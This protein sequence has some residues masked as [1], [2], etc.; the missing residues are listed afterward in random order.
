MKNLIVEDDRQDTHHDILDN[1]GQ[2]KVADYLRQQL[3]N[4]DVFRIVSAYFTIYGF[5]ALSSELQTVKNVKFLFGDP[6]SV[7]NLDPSAKFEKT[8]HIE[9]G[10]SPKFSLRQKFLAKKCS[11]WV[12]SD[13]VKIR[14]IS[15][16]NFLHGKMYLTETS[17]FGATVVGSSNFTRSGLGYGERHNIEINSAT[18]NSSVR[19]GLQNWFDK[20]WENRDLTKDVKESVIRALERIGMDVPPELIYYKTLFELFKDELDSGAHG[21]HEL[22]ESHLYDTQ[23]WGKL[24]NFQKDGARTV[25]NRLK[26]LGGCILADSVGLG[27]TYTTLAVIKYFELR[28]ERV[29]V[30]CPRKLRENWGLYPIANANINNPFPKDRFN[31]TLLS[32]TDLSRYYGNVGGVDLANFMWDGF[33][34]IVIDE[35]H[36]F[37]NES[38]PVDID[39]KEFHHTR[40][41]RLLSEVLKKGVKSKVLMLSATPVNTTLYDLRNQIYLMTEHRDDVW[42]DTL[43]ISN[44]GGVLRKAQD[45]FHQWEKERENVPSLDKSSLT[46]KLGDDFFRL[47]GGMSIARSRR[48]IKK[49]YIDD[50]TRIGKFPER[51]APQNCYPETDIEQ[52]LSYDQLALDIDKLSLSLYRPS[53]YV[54]SESAKA[55]LE[56]ER[57]IHQFNQEDREKFLIGMI[58]T[59]FLKRLESSI[60]SLSTTL[61]RTLNKFED[62]LDKIERYKLGKTHITQISEMFPDEDEDD[63]EFFINQA[64]KPF[65]LRELDLDRWS[66]HLRLDSSILRDLLKIVSKV[67]PSRDGKL[68]TLKKYIQTRALDPTKDIDDCN[69]RKI[70]IFTTFTDTAR[71]LYSELQEFSKELN[72][73]MAMVS[74]DECITD[75]GNGSNDFNSILTNFAPKGRNRSEEIQGSI[76]VLIATDCVSEGQN[77]QDCDTVVNYDIHWNPVRIIQRFGRIDRIGS[78]NKSVRMINFWPTDNLELYLNL[79]SRVEARMALADASGSG[80]DDIIH[81]VETEKVQA[82]IEFRDTQIKKM[83]DEI[84]DIDEV[85]DG[86]VM[87]DFTLDIFYAQ[88]FQFLQSNRKKLENLDSG[89]YAVTKCIGDNLPPGVIFV[90]RQ[91]NAST[92]RRAKVASQVHPFYLAYIQKN[93]D[94]RF[95]CSNARKILDSFELATSGKDSPDQ[96]LCDLFDEETKGGELMLD[97]DQLLDAV[98]RHFVKAHAE[99]NRMKIGK[100]GGHDGIIEK[101]ENTPQQ[102]ENF[103]LVTWLVLQPQ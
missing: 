90:L 61:K 52:E 67:T 74:G 77:L 68:L 11:E 22:G 23:I 46:E 102:A 9:D 96:K 27:K 33:D 100:G 17:E 87:S 49:F 30:L 80:D 18:T 28:N 97:Y 84:L 37:R 60:F 31:Y 99:K 44:I 56:N 8:Y 81:E 71:Y 40:Y 93:G 58:R 41:S 78:R 53:N 79:Q 72:L 69:H 25:I 82:E 36:N 51:E 35:S 62:M 88:L 14:S 24:Y 50:L 103:E 94:I 39:G 15:K 29:L 64:R 45:A 16:A 73:T 54:I 55:R 13:N 95:G 26:Q 19:K 4:A 89:A 6:E 42:R 98:I 34:L 92:A 12:K 57:K 1:Q 5:E 91:K 21:E 48:M 76:D 43:G 85:K 66:N 20:L 59:N 10:L 70:L 75:F 65:H 86:F 101:K 2:R 32:H 63:D 7:S 83:Q 3:S 47:L 38:K